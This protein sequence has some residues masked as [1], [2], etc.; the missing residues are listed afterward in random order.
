[1]TKTVT[2]SCGE[3]FSSPQALWDHYLAE[4]KESSAEALKAEN[5]RLTARV[6]ELERVK[7]SAYTERN[8]CVALI[9][10]MARLLGWKAGIARHPEEDKSWED[11]WRTLAF[12]DLPTGQVSWHFH[13]SECNLLS[14]LPVYRGTWDGHDTPEKYRRVRAALTPP[15]EPKENTP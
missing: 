1:M 9:A 4:P 12:I 8:Q 10:T 5:L 14:N 3:E 11:D 2:C 7:N 15:P 13:D 6:A